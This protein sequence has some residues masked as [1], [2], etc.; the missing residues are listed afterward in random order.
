MSTYTHKHTHISTHAHT[1]IHTYTHAHMYTYTHTHIHTYTHTHIRT[2]THTHIH[3]YTQ[4]RHVNVVQFVGAATKPPQL[5]ILTGHA[6]FHPNLTPK[7]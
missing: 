5:L 6:I 4:M 7:T 3:T 1:H 2:Y